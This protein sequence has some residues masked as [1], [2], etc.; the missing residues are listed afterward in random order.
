[1]HAFQVP[2]QQLRVQVTEP[3]PIR[4]RN[5]RIPHYFLDNPKYRLD[6]RGFEAVQDT[7]LPAGVLQAMLHPRYGHQH[8]VDTR[9]PAHTVPPT[10]DGAVPGRKRDIG[11]HV[12]RLAACHIILAEITRIRQQ[13]IRASQRHRESRVQLP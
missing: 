10:T 12:F 1:M 9:V 6:H 8:L 3:P 11:C 7:A 2:R 4:R 5:R 13:P